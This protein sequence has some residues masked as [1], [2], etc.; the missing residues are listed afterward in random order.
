MDTEAEEDADAD[1]VGAD[2]HADADGGRRGSGWKCKRSRTVAFGVDVGAAAGS[3]PEGY[4]RWPWGASRFHLLIFTERCRV[5]YGTKQR[6]S[7][8][9]WAHLLSSRDGEQWGPRG[10]EALPAFQRHQQGTGAE[11]PWEGTGEG[12]GCLDPWVTGAPAGGPYRPPGGKEGGS[13]GVQGLPRQCFALN[14]TG[15]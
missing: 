10:A 12:R 6:S 5:R 1:T 3:D 15:F 14:A 2:T 13:P 4:C 8:L 7:S 11:E 9:L